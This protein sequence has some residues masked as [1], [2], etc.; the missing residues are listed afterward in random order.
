MNLWPFRNYF[1]K[2]GSSVSRGRGAHMT[3]AKSRIGSTLSRAGTTLKRQY[4]LWPIIAMVVLSIIGFSVQRSISS[5][6]KASLASEL[7]TLLNVETA[8]LENWYASQKSSA[9]LIANN[10]EIRRL[11]NELV[12]VHSEEQSAK[13]SIKLDEGRVDLE[14]LIM[15]Q[16]NLREHQ[17]FVIADREHRILASNHDE[18]VGK[19][20]LAQFNDFINGALDGKLVVSAPF[21]SVIALKDSSGN[22]RAGMPTMFVAAPVRDDRLQICG[23]LALRIPPEREFTRILQL[24][25]VGESGETYAFN[26]EGTMVSNSRF[27]QSLILTGILA[28]QPDSQSI[29]NLQLRD[30]GG[31]MTLG[32]RPAKRRAEMPLTQ[33]VQTAIGGKDGVDVEGYADY[34][35]VPVVGAWKWLADYNIGIATEIDRAEAF[36]PMTILGRVFAAL[37]GLLFVATIAILGFSIVVGRVRREAQ[38]AAIEA[39]QLGQYRL[40]EK[41]GSGAMGTVYKGHHAMMRRPTAIKLLNLDQISSASIARFEREVQITCQLTHPNTIAIFDYGRTPEGVFYYAMEYLDGLDLQQLIDQYGPQPESRVIQILL[42]ICGSLYEAHTHGLVHRD[43]KP[44]NIMLNRRGGQPDVVKVLDFGLVKQVD[45]IGQDTGLAGTPLYMS[46]EAIQS[47]TLV[48]GCSDIYAVGAIGYFLLTGKSVFE[49][50]SLVQLMQMHVTEAPIPPSLR[51]NVNVSEDL[52]SILLGCLEKSR[53]RRP[54]TARDLAQQLLRCSAAQDWKLA[55]AETWWMS[56]DRRRMQV[57]DGLK[58]MDSTF[59][60]TINTSTSLRQAAVGQAN[61]NALKSDMSTGAAVSAEPQSNSS[62]RVE[63]G[64]EQ[65]MVQD[66]KSDGDLD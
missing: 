47:P 36:R 64:F 16:L 18:L 53:A 24:G 46:P 15:S 42:Q 43:I 7:H 58:S 17:G 13:P 33:M 62:T 37:F 28:D 66:P 23:V 61:L 6:M 39:Q 49:A 59:K 38:K 9:E 48:D 30:P 55:D 20:H 34:R 4:W 57:T 29:L 22:Y 60:G 1:S 5:T 65:T 41:L 63:L 25:Q 56:H 11:C 54:Q 27:D 50:T 3:F 31:D 2:S 19:Q 32:F 35:G 10:S 44:A 12:L 8:M 14:R 26:K 40:E 45:E 21:Q 51:V 52:E